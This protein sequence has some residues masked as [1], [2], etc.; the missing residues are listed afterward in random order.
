MS[1]ELPEKI[2]IKIHDKNQFDS[3]MD[4]LYSRGYVQNVTYRINNKKDFMNR[5]GKS[6][7]WCFICLGMCECKRII[8]IVNSSYYYKHA[9]NEISYETFI[10][11]Y[12][13]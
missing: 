10:K 4:E 12:V 9:A 7:W 8:Y 6:S 2:I 13:N 5:H 1:K 11:D 3:C